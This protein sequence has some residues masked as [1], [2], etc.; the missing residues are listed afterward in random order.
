M[1]LAGSVNLLAGSSGAGKTA[2]LAYLARLLQERK[3]LF[4]VEPEKSPYLAYISVDKSWQQSSSRWFRLE[5]IPEIKHYC[6]ADDTTF[7]KSRMR[8]KNDRTAIFR[9]CLAKVTPDGK[10]FPPGALL[11]FD[12]IALF[13]GGNLVDYDASAVACMEIREVLREMG[14]PAVL[15]SVHGGKMKTDKKQGYARLQDHILGSAAL[16]GYTD[17]QLYLASADELKLK[18]ALLHVSPH[19]GTPMNLFLGRETDG[20]F[21]FAG[22]PQ[23]LAAP[24]PSWVVKVLA[25]ATNNTLE[26]A[27]LLQEAVDRDCGQK[28]LQRLLQQEI[29]AGRVER[30]AHGKYRLVRPN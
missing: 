23:L 15:G 28:K 19:H 30:A 14:R 11:L 5:G 25:D 16:Y 2:L 8:A 21:T 29:A 17:T 1:F 20:R 22:A 10:Q 7:R 4:G 6:L 18:T 26:F 12:P 3:P 13:L 9:E 24:G 27:E